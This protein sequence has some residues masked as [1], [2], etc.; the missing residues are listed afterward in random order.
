MNLTNPLVSIVIPAYNAEKYIAETINSVIYQT[1]PNWELIIVID[2]AK[3]GTEDVIK[4]FLGDTRI[5][6]ISKKNTGVSDT[7]NVGIKQTKGRYI[8]FLDADDVWMPEN[9]E[10]KIQILETNKNTAW[11]YSNMYEADE[12]MNITGEAKSGRED[13]IL[14]NI[15]LWEGEVVPGPCSNI[16]ISRD[17]IEKGILFDPLL[18]TAADQDFC[19]QLAANGFQGKHIKAPLWKYRILGNSMSR[20]LKVM[21]SD[22]IY[23]YKKANRNNVFRSWFFKQKCFSNLYLLLAGSWWVQGKNK[24]RATY[25]VIL[26]LVYNPFNSLKLLKKFI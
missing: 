21:E 1:Y 11:V 9:L 26:S 22:H 13:N 8:A 5:R 12:N 16:I 23:V 18:S 3:D 24:M 20:N 25:F 19:I 7:R 17:C 6:Y 4:T 10:L 15:L 14:D 2:G